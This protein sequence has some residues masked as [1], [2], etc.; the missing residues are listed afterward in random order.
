M[1]Y[2]FNQ[3]VER[4]VKFNEV[5]SV[6]DC[7]VKIYTITNHSTFR[8]NELLNKAI[9]QLPEWLN[10]ST[11]FKLDTYN[12]AFLIVHEGRDGLWAL[13]NWWVGGEMLRTITYFAKFGDNSEFIP[14]PNKGAMACVWEME[15]LRHE[16]NSWVVH[17]LKKPHQ[18]NFESYLSDHLEGKI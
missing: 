17:I 1:E 9:A 8:S 3:Y 10:D 16:R 18:P 6:N 7:R 4:T 14:L 12:V 5:I 2:Q 15:V 13:I 11:E